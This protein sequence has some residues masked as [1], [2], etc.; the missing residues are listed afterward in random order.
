MRYATTSGMV[1]AAICI[2]EAVAGPAHAHLHQRAQ[3]EK[4]E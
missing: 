4:K 3:K 2:G 1:V